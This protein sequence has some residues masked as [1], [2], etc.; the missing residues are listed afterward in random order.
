M[1][2]RFVLTR[3]AFWVWFQSPERLKMLQRISDNMA[4][5][6]HRRL[7]R[8]AGIEPLT[9]FRDSMKAFWKEW[10]GSSEQGNEKVLRALYA[11]FC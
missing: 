4:G 8:P 11:V 7:H 9:F 2:S 6:Y 5:C 10:K 1:Q 3:D